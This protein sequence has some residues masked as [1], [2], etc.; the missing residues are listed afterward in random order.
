M[1]HVYS[2]SVS[3][4]IRSYWQWENEHRITTLTAEDQGGGGKGKES[5]PPLN[6]ITTSKSENIQLPSTRYTVYIHTSQLGIQIR[7][8]HGIPVIAGLKGFGAASVETEEDEMEQSVSEI[9]QWEPI[10]CLH[11]ENKD[12]S[13]SISTS[14][15]PFDDLSYFQSRFGN[16]ETTQTAE[17]CSTFALTAGD[18]YSI[19]LAIKMVLECPSVF[20]KGIRKLWRWKPSCDREEL[21]SKTGLN[22]FVLGLLKRL[23]PQARAHFVQLQLEDTASLLTSDKF[24]VSFF[25]GEEGDY[26][27]LDAESWPEFIY[28]HHKRLIVDFALDDDGVRGQREDDDLVTDEAV[29]AAPNVVIEEVNSHGNVM[30]RDVVEQDNAGSNEVASAVGDM[31]GGGLKAVEPNGSAAAALEKLKWER[32]NDEMNGIDST[33]SAAENENCEEVR[34]ADTTNSINIS[35][36]PEGFTSSP[37]VIPY[38]SDDSLS[39]QVCDG[40]MVVYMHCCCIRIFY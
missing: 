38:P 5:A 33:M 18:W 40:W 20:G 4:L 29:A 3:C 12:V 11:E 22:Q 34:N 31:N 15:S 17:S 26:I 28:L 16:L 8:L 36:S 32:N 10:R 30:E 1:L 6:T 9:F 21:G 14:Q 24:R 2:F 23:G 13:Q 27:S 39:Q 37:Q 35:S 19:D 7:E 25:D